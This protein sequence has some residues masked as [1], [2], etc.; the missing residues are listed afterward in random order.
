MQE[1]ED[2]TD[3][4]QSRTGEIGERHVLWLELWIRHRVGHIVPHQCRTRTSSRAEWIDVVSFVAP[5]RPPRHA[6]SRR[7]LPKEIDLT[8]LT[9][10]VFNVKAVE[11]FGTAFFGEKLGTLKFVSQKQLF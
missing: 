2:K 4:H 7:H 6:D 9:D 3:F 1:D 5:L 10:E 8:V 11:F